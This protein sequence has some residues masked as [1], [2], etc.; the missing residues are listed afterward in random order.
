MRKLDTGNQSKR[1][2]VEDG[3]GA[4]LLDYLT[5]ATR[6]GLSQEEIAQE[7]EGRTGTR[8]TRATVCNWLKACGFQAFIIYRR[9]RRAA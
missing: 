4:S 7:I 3:L 6:R 8:V 1:R 2:Q 5:D 9:N